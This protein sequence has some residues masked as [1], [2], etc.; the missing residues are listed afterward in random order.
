MLSIVQCDLSKIT[1][2]PLSHNRQLL[3]RLGLSPSTSKTLSKE[4]LREILMLPIPMIL[5]FL[6]SPKVTNPS[7]FYDRLVKNDLSPVICLE[8]QL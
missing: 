3:S 2:L 5:P 7:S 6:L 8:N 1:R 4:G